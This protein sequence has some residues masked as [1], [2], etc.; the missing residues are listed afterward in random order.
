MEKISYSSQERYSSDGGNSSSFRLNGEKKSQSFSETGQGSVHSSS[1]I[2][3]NRSG[4][5]QSFSHTAPTPLTETED[6]N[7]WI[8]KVLDDRYEILSLVGEGGMAWVYRATDHRLNRSVAVKIMREDAAAD[9]SLR[10]RFCAESHA[11]AMLSHPNIVA[12]Y[13]VS[14]SD[15][16]EYIVMELVDGVTLLRYMEKKGILPWHEALHFT[17]Q[18]AKALSHA[19]SRGI[20]HRDIKPHNI[21]LLRDGTIKV[22]DFGIAALENELHE[23]NGEAVGSIHYIAP[24]Q[25][26]GEYPD[27]R[28]DIYSLGVVMYEMFTGRKPFIGDTIREIAVKHMNA[29]PTSML[30]LNPELP[31]ELERIT[32][33]AMCPDISKRY[34]NASALVDDIDAFLRD[35][36]SVSPMPDAELSASDVDR[37]EPE[38]QT[39][40]S[41]RRS[42]QKRA[43]NFT[44]LSGSFLLLGFAVF[45][46]VFLYNFWLREV[47]SPAVRV[48][49]PDF[50]GQ[51]FDQIYANPEYRGTYSFDVVYLVNTATAPG[52]VL[53]QS[54]H[55]GRSIMVTADG[56]EVKLSVSIGDTTTTIPDVSGIDY[57]SATAVLRQCGLYMEIVNSYSESVD[58]DKVIRTDPAAGT[59]VTTTSLI[60][61]YISCGTELR[62]LTVPNLIGLSEEAAIS[63]IESNGFSYGWSQHESSDLTGGTVIGQSL[64]AFSSAEEHSNIYLTV[65]DGPQLP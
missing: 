36:E 51:N 3:L 56:V 25:A 57:R 31:P 58:R 23:S 24:E 27:P 14:H 30:Q 38:D 64:D 18:I 63:Q 8:G 32:L 50:V 62:Y 7:R 2:P 28:S 35:R 15:E 45:L 10:S 42:L 47:F 12:V 11:V 43:G 13:D 21:M 34:Q 6:K 19:H 40:R 20:I 59:E 33:Q 53:S 46:G 29:T 16:L 55:P 65:S 54:P 61:V 44:W 26:R 9:E 22:A 39:K 41:F 48:T 37:E 52:T 49:L 1:A 5:G 4:I 17:R 60:Y